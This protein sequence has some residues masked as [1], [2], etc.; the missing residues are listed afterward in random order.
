MKTYEELLDM[1]DV[2]LD[3]RDAWKRAKEEFK[4]PMR[5]DF[6]RKVKGRWVR[7]KF[8]DR[9]RFLKELQKEGIRFILRKA[10]RGGCARIYIDEQDYERVEEIFIRLFL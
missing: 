3:G 5:Y 7:I 1:Y 8:M 4:K 10:T 9:V 6:E 2:Y